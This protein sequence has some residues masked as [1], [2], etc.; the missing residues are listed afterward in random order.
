MHTNLEAI[1]IILDAINKADRS[2]VAFI[3]TRREND[4]AIR[5]EYYENE[6]H[7][8]SLPVYDSIR[9]LYKKRDSTHCKSKLV[10]PS[11]TSYL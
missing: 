8:G 1:E 3:A 4:M 2:H 9:K 6:S 10:V 7:T 5:K 11:K